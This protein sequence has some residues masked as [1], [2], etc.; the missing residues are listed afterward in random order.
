[1]NG[2]KILE[3]SLMWRFGYPKNPLDHLNLVSHSAL[4]RN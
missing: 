1:M 4:G 3:F 2:G